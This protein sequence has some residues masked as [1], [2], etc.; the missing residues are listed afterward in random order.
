MA[1]D[2]ILSAWVCIHIAVDQVPL[3]ITPVHLAI[4][5]SEV[6]FPLICNLE[7]GFDIQIPT[8]PNHN[9]CNKIFEPSRYTVS[10]ALNVPIWSPRLYSRAR[11][12]LWSC[13]CPKRRTEAA[14]GDVIVTA[15]SLGNQLMT[16]PDHTANLTLGLLFPIP[17]FPPVL[18][19]FVLVVVRDDP[20]QNGVAQVIPVCRNHVAQVIPCIHCNH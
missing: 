9:V 13:V 10:E 11:N 1:V 18:N 14:V 17:T 8:F 16:I 19:I 2:A 20:F 6:R 7:R 12:A 5:P 3:A 4:N 15:T